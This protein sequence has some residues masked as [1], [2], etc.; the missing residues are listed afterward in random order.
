MQ[1]RYGVKIH[2]NS[3][4]ACFFRSKPQE[5]EW[6]FH[7][8]VFF[9]P[10][11][12]HRA[13]TSKPKFVSYPHDMPQERNRADRLWATFAIYPPLQ[14][15]NFLWSSLSIINRAVKFLSRVRVHPPAE[16]ASNSVLANFVWF[17]NY[18]FPP[19]SEKLFMCGTKLTKLMTRYAWIRYKNILCTNC[20]SNRVEF[21]M[22]FT[23]ARFLS[24]ANKT[25]CKLN[26]PLYFVLSD[27]RT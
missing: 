12:T 27:L 10:K 6:E 19:T 25:L 11:E 24:A 8:E 4:S 9:S 5:S 21:A 22:Q 23:I 13:T 15:I 16:T 7:A 18:N 3:S 14:V 26:E 1:E 2:T 17:E 20:Q